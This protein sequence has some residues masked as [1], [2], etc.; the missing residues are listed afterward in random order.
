M[1]TAAILLAGGIGH[2]FKSSIPKQYV[3]VKNQEICLYSFHQFL[4]STH[5]KTIVVVADPMYHHLFS[6]TNEKNII[7]ALPGIRRQD[8]LEN[9]ILAL[10]NITPSL[11]LV[12][13]AA[14]P[15]ITQELIS[16]LVQEGERIGACAPAIPISATIRKVE[17]SKYLT[18]PRDGLHIIQTPQ[19]A[20]Y[21]WICRGLEYCS[22]NAIE[23]TDELALVEAIG[24]PYEL[25]QGDPRNI[26]ITH[27]LDLTF[28]TPHITI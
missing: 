15:F 23:A 13:D 3:K 16:T 25:I 4:K 22:Q 19:V 2:R 20:R 28:I 26:K 21:E 5:I 1:T 14:R 11:V 27:P 18:I 7:F 12:H 10:K 6:T 9:G 8:S 17:G 24:K